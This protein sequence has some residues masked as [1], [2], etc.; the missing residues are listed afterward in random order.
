MLEMISHSLHNHPRNECL[1]CV[2]TKERSLAGLICRSIIYIFFVEQPSKDGSD[3]LLSLV[4]S[5]LGEI[6]GNL[7]QDFFLSYSL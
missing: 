2:I 1:S 7:K 4:H 5:S 6:F 3:I